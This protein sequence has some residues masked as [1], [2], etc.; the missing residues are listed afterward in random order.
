MSQDSRS[1]IG[2]KSCPMTGSPRLSAGNRGRDRTNRD[3]ITFHSGSIWTLWMMRDHHVYGNTFARLK[4]TKK[5]ESFSTARRW[6]IQYN[7]KRMYPEE[8]DREW[9]DMT[10]KTVTVDTGH[11]TKFR[12]RSGAHVDRVFS[13]RYGMVSRRGMRAL[14]VQLQASNLKRARFE[15]RDISAC[16]D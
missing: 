3:E 5:S 9:H 15:K 2:V 4:S 14:R 16:K 8:E 13:F 6:G 11:S 7:G 12:L 1:R 10:R